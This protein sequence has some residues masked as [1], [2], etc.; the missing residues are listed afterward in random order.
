MQLQD[1]STGS[2]RRLFAQQHGLSMKSSQPFMSLIFDRHL[3]IPVDPAHCIC[4][5]LDTVLIKATIQLLSAAGR[6]KF[7]RLIRQL[8]LPPGWPRFQDPIAHIRSY[9][10]SDLA[11]LIM[12]GPFVL[13]QLSKEDYSQQHLLSLRVRLGRN[14]LQRVLDDILDCWIKLAAMSAK[15]FAPQIPNYDDLQQSIIILARQLVLVNFQ[16]KLFH[17]LILLRKH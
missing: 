8:E 6:D 14:S 5:G 12:I 7:S 4:Q 11:R 16:Q 3:Q 13:V 15:V 9:F 2:E 10:F 1:K 17:E